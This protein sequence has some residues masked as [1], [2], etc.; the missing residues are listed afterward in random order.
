MLMIGEIAC[1][2]RTAAL[3]KIP[4]WSSLIQL[5]M[6]VLQDYLSLCTI[7][8]VQMPFSPETWS[9]SLLLK[10]WKISHWVFLV[11]YC[12]IYNKTRYQK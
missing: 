4:E 6:E 2:M 11:S 10:I 5:I 8:D 12:L 7:S 3:E 1:T 9:I